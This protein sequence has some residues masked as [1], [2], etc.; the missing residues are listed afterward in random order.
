MNMVIDREWMRAGNLVVEASQVDRFRDRAPVHEGW[1][2]FF[3]AHDSDKR[4][5]RWTYRR[6]G[7]LE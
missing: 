4:T 2:V 6:M 3:V 5:A 7:E 1:Q